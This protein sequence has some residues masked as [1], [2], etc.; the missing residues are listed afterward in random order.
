MLKNKSVDSD[1]KAFYDPNA[2]PEQRDH[3]YKKVSVC[4]RAYLKL[5][6]DMGVSQSFLTS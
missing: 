5:F 6:P 2:E 1:C 4:S 3:P